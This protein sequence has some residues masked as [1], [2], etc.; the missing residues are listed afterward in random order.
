MN[1]TSGTYTNTRRNSSEPSEPCLWNL[2]Q[3]APELSA[4]LRNLPRPSGTNLSEPSGTYLRNLRQH[5]PEP[6]GTFRN[7]PPEPTPAHARTLRN[8]W[9]QKVLDFSSVLI[10]LGSCR[11]LVATPTPKYN[12]WRIGVSSLTQERRSLMSS[13]K[14]GPPTPRPCQASPCWPL[15]GGWRG[16]GLTGPSS[17]QLWAVTCSRPWLFPLPA[18]VHQ[19]TRGLVLHHRSLEARGQRHS[20]CRRQEERQPDNAKVHEFVG[21]NPVLHLI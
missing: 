13:S 15:S 18:N 20:Y 8:L 14:T 19:L 5:T 7:P 1:P 2:Y 6:S 21:R 4:T 9:G 3:H 17:G 16:T 12:S 11:L 10:F